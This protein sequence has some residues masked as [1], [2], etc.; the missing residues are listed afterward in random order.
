[1][2]GEQA[3]GEGRERRVGRARGGVDPGRRAELERAEVV[4]DVAGQ[5]DEDRAGR[6]GQ[7]DLGGAMH[8]A[9]KVGKARDLGCP[10]D[11]R[12]RDRQQGRVEQG[13]HEA[14]ALLLLAGGD[15]QRRARD[16]GR[17]ERADR[18][19]EAGGDVDVAGGE[20][21]RGAC[22]AVGHRQHDRLL[23][24]EDVAHLGVVGER[25][26][27]RQLGRAGVAEDLC[28][29]FGL[30]QLDEGAAAADLVG[31]RAVGHGRC[32]APWRDPGDAAT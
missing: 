3:L 4:E 20:P 18:V 31:W 22:E 19:A 11:H 8:D 29:A 16:I 25:V 15:D 10:F 24:A 30:K 6:R 28:D 1:M 23:Q 14:V 2:R 27:D 9:R 26:H 5:R 32:G 21:A 17:I 12:C 7:R 13:L